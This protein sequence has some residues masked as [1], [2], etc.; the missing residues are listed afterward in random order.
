MNWGSRRLP[1]T[2]HRNVVATAAMHGIVQRVADVQRRRNE[3]ANK[4][5]PDDHHL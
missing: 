2:I 1:P 5:R 3:H 4:A